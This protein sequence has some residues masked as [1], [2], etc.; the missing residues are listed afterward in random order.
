[1]DLVMACGGDGTVTACVT[2]LA[3]TGV[4]LALLPAGTGNLLANNLRIPSD[5][6]GAI[7][8]A[9]HGDRVQIDVGAL[10]APEKDRFVIMSGIGFDAAMLADA[11]P[12]LKERIGALAYLVSGLRHLRRQRTEFHVRLD[13]RAPTIRRAQGVL[14]GNFGRLQGGLP[15]L[16]Q[17]C[18]T[19][20][21]LD[22]GIL[23]TQSMMDWLALAVRILV[24]RRSP[25]PGLE[26]FQARRVEVRC[27]QPQ[28]FQRDGDVLGSRCVLEI[29]VV[30]KALTLCVP[31]Q[32]GRA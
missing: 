21:L 13:D 14:I 27:D 4:P 26:L 19:D 25:G 11:N 31:A 9:L 12:S 16:P 30:P 1:V 3:G 29:E 28:P 6:D 20:G 22:V 7:D 2:V 8:V 32:G 15:V 5:L 17:A 24:R 23:Q 10:S 18:P